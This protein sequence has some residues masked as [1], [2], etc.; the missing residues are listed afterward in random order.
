MQKAQVRRVI[1]TCG[2]IF[3]I[4]FL[5]FKDIKVNIKVTEIIGVSNKW[6]F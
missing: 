3:F 5:S 2:F 1:N 4:L 6:D